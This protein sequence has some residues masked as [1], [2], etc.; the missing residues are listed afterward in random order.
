MINCTVL[1]FLG[2]FNITKKPSLIT[3]SFCSGTDAGLG[4]I[5]SMTRIK[6]HPCKYKAMG[7]YIMKSAEQVPSTVH[8]VTYTKHSKF[9]HQRT[10]GPVNAHL[11][12]EIYTNKLV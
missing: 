7:K 9:K 4:E 2:D 12:P 5:E 3:K 10:N 6:E 1:K 8:L 11:K